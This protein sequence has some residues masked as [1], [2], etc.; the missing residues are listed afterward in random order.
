MVKIAIM[1]FGVVG[2]GV[3][4]VLTKNAASIAKRAGDEIGIKY[5]LDIR[6]FPDHPAKNLIIKDFDKILNDDEVS[7]VVETIG[8]LEPAYTYTKKSLEKGSMLLHQTKNLL[9]SMDQSF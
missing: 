9:Q 2:S 3:W 8:G 6:D 4:E 1:G 7:I 5:I